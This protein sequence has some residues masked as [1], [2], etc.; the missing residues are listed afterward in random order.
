MTLTEE[1][2]KEQ[3]HSFSSNASN[4]AARSC[5]RC[6]PTLSPFPFLSCFLQ[7]IHIRG[8]RWQSSRCNCSCDL[9][10]QSTCPGT[11]FSFPS[12]SL[13][14]EQ[15]SDRFLNLCCESSR[16][17]VCQSIRFRSLCHS[18]LDVSYRSTRLSSLYPQAIKLFKVPGKKCSTLL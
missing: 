5:C 6:S 16:R 1:A 12:L 10:F 8:P 18:P 7:S 17:K 2:H 9:V 3:T 13:L 14:S 4:C 11:L 15:E